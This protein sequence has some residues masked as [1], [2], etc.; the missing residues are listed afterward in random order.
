MK[1]IA[2]FV[3]G[4]TEL[5]IVERLFTEVAGPIKQLAIQREELRGGQHIKLTARGCPGEDADFFVLL[6]NCQS[7]G[8]V[9]PAILERFESL[10]NQGY[11][12]VIGLRDMHPDFTLSQCSTALRKINENLGDAELKAEILFAIHEIESWFLVEHSHLLRLDPSLTVQKIE[13][14]LGV[15]LETEIIEKI[16]SPA[17]LLDKIYQL[18]GKRYK[19]RSTDSQRVAAFLNYDELY[20]NGRERMPSL[21]KFFAKVDHFYAN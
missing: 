12:E 19:K 5:A 11:S 18:I 6:V 4:H 3:E 14:E 2:V 21:D 20:E 1:K 17:T 16:R 9:K 8:K 15:N 7:D 10:K 13:A